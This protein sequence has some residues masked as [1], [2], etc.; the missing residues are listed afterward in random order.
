MACGSQ[1]I[2]GEGEATHARARRSSCRTPAASL[3]Q[4]RK[5]LRFRRAEREGDARGSFRR[6]KP[7]DYLPPHVRSGLAGGLPELLVQYGPHGRRAGSSGA[8]RRVICGD[9]TSGLSEDRG[10]QEAYGLAL[11]LGVFER[12]RF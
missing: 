11:Q 9:L 4:S 3:G 6:Q 12:Q 8:T 7:A 2:A 1:K 5:K 10:V